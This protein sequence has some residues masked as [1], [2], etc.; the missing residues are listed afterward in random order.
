MST[1]TR[2][3]TSNVYWLF[4]LHVEAWSVKSGQATIQHSQLLATAM[5]HISICSQIATEPEVYTT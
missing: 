2:V 1:W 5:H 4:Q 3:A